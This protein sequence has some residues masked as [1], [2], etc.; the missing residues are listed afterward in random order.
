[1]L[2]VPNFNFDVFTSDPCAGKTCGTGLTCSGGSCVCVGSTGASTFCN[3]AISNVCDSGT[4]KCG[5]SNACSTTSTTTQVSC[6]DATGMMPTFG[7]TTAT[8]KVSC[9]IN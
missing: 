3:L 2:E 1:M 5:S 6:L 9:F 8:C 7:D 4:C